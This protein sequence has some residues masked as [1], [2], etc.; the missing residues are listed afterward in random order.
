[1]ELNEK[2]RVPMGIAVAATVFVC[3]LVIWAAR[4]EWVASATARALVV[5]IEERKQE[6]EDLR[7]EVRNLSRK[8]LLLIIGLGL[9]LRLLLFI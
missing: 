1:M 3:G 7:T 2:T 5:N 8:L 4:V 9:L 6:S